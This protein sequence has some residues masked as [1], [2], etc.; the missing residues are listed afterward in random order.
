MESVIGNG[1]GWSV[2]PRREG[3]PGQGR[4]LG[5]CTLA[6]APACS[7]CCS[8]TAHADDGRCGSIGICRT[9]KPLAKSCR[10][11]VLPA[12]ADKNRDAVIPPDRKGQ[13][14]EKQ[15]L[16]ALQ[17]RVRSEVTVAAVRAP[18]TH[19]GSR[20]AP[21]LRWSCRREEQSLPLE[22]HVPAPCQHRT[23]QRQGS[24]CLL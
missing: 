17:Q 16:C 10:L 15:Q 3:Q 20:T 4:A 9:R 24:S 23:K 21:G 1:S 11:R 14:S 12:P 22:G 18:R 19:A 2:R 6:N 5:S 7:F 8:I 13:R